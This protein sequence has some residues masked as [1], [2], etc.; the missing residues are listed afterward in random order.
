MDNS[1]ANENKNKNNLDVVHPLKTMMATKFKSLISDPLEAKRTEDSGGN[2][3]WLQVYFSCEVKISLELLGE[4][5]VSWKQTEPRRSVPL[6]RV[7]KAEGRGEAHPLHSGDYGE[8][9]WVS[10]GR[11]K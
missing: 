4:K 6:H 10:F 9:L 8:F 1:V 5:F 11:D 3:R 2:G 7:P